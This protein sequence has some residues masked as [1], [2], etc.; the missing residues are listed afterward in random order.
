MINLLLIKIN[1]FF[2]LRYKIIL[3]NVS[4]KIENASNLNKFFHFLFLPNKFC[5]NYTKN[6]NIN[7]HIFPV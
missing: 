4:M 1:I 7:F 3:R 6:I 2:I 5:L